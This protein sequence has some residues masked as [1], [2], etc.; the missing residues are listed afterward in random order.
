[1]CN[2]LHMHCELHGLTSTSKKFR[3]LHR[4]GHTH[5]KNRPSRRATWKRNQTLSLHMYH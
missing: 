3:G 4:K 2:P 1:L 5:H